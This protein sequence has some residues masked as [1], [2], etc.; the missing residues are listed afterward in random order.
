[1]DE[2]RHS[3][4]AKL[5]EEAYLNSKEDFALWMWNNHL[6]IVARKAQEMAIKFQAKEDLAVAGAWLHDFGDA[7]V[8]RHDPKHEEFCTKE[9]SRVLALAGYS[10]D[11]IKEILEVIIKPHSCKNGLFPQTLEG[12]VMASADAWAHLMSD[13][14]LQFAW[15]NLPDNSTYAEYKTWVNE[16]IDRDFN[17]KIFF[18]EI[19]KEV[20]TRY[21][22][23]KNIFA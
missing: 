14:Y 5:I 7:Y 6:Q 8:D 21:L 12:K 10:T 22:A 20:E 11:E 13:F 19:K 23:L 1:M 2:K 17:A 18:P 16:K 9:S 3:K 4:L 15:L